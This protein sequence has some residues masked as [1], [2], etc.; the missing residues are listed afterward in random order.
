MFPVFSRWRSN[1][2]LL[3]P[4]PNPSYSFPVCMR[5]FIDGRSPVV[6]SFSLPLAAPVISRI[7]SCSQPRGSLSFGGEA[8]ISEAPLRMLKF[9]RIWALCGV[10][11]MEDVERPLLDGPLSS[12][13]FEHSINGMG[14]VQ[15]S[16]EKKR[17]GRK[18]RRLSPFKKEAF[19][20]ISSWGT[21][22]QG[23]PSLTFI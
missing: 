4:T 13:F 7:F 18:R 14:V 1:M 22:L 8:F 2:F 9:V 5:V 21:L 12:G 17:W 3:R 20:V 11:Q 6:N 16:T 19:R 15:R 23:L 10:N